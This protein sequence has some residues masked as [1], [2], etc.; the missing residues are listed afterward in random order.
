M[1]CVDQDQMKELKISGRS[2]SP[3]GRSLM[4]EF[5]PC[6]GEEANGCHVDKLIGRALKSAK[7]VVL[8]NQIKFDQNV[9]GADSIVQE[10]RIISEPLNMVWNEQQAKDFKVWSWSE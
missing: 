8:H 5:Y 3:T 2:S 4:I 10:S 1:V 6:L 9:F 7:L